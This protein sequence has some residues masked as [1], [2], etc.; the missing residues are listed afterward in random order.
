M[1][2]QWTSALQRSSRLAWNVGDGRTQGAR[3]DLIDSYREFAC[4]C[5]ITIVDKRTKEYI[6]QIADAE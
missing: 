1:T 6:R 2:S 4:Y 3:L 5:N